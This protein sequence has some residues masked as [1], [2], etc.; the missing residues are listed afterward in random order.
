MPTGV[1]GQ[2]GRSGERHSQAGGGS[3]RARKINA[4]PRC[5]AFAAPTPTRTMRASLTVREK[6]NREFAARRP[7]R[8]WR[9]MY[10]NKNYKS[11]ADCRPSFRSIPAAVLAGDSPLREIA[12]APA[13]AVRPGSSTT[14]CSRPCAVWVSAP[15]DPCDDRCRGNYEL[16]S[17]PGR[18]S[19]KMETMVRQAAG[20]ASPRLI[21]L[22]RRQSGFDAVTGPSG[23]ER[24]RGAIRA[25]I[26]QRS[27]GPPFAL[28]GGPA[29]LA[30]VEPRPGVLGPSRRDLARG[31]RDLVNDEY[32][33]RIVGTAAISST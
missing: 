28:T 23:G 18:L 8:V 1:D 4:T 10:P 25:G 5:D 30:S 15:P 7:A 12:L 22:G 29:K 17:P 32:I 6:Q 20:R 19:K 2:W 3:R 16:P 13:T 31:H 33:T 9:Q 27:A 21:A 14:G 26:C 11:A 24:N